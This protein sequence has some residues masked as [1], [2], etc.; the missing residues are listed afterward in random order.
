LSKLV[1][2]IQPTLKP[3]DHPY[4]NGA[5][6]PNYDEYD[7]DDMEV[8]G[9]IPDDID[10]I[11]VRNTENPIH[12]PIGAYHPFDGDGMLHMMRFSGGKAQYKNRFI[13]TSGFEA[14]A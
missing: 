8:I 12:E 5:W 4:Q 3:S 11:Y 2:T 14:E 6:T 1:N 7:A 13:R 10:G 9:T